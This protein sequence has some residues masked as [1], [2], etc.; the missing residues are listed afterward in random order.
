MTIYGAESGIAIVAARVCDFRSLANI[1]VELNNLTVLIGANNAGKTSFLDALFAAIGAGR[2]SLGADDVRLAPGELTA[3]KSRE[4]TIDLMLRPVDADGKVSST[5]PEGSFWTNLWGTTGIA[6]DDDISEFTGIRTTLRW[7]DVRGE[8]VLERRFLKEWKA[9]EDWKTAATQERPVTGAQ[10]EPLA[11]HYIDAKRDLDEDLRKPGSFWRRLTEDLGLSVDEI[12]EM[13][14]T[15]SGINERIVNKSAILKHLRESLSGL[16]SVVASDGG[17][18]EVAAVAR[19]LRDLSKGVDVAFNTPGAQSFPLARHGM[20]TRSLAALMVF[21]AY[22]SW[23]N[24]QATEGGDSIH[25]VLALEEPEAHLHPQAQRSLFSHIKHVAGQRIVSTHSPY[26]TGQAALEDLRLFFKSKGD[27]VVNKLD[28][29]TLGPNDVRKLQNTVIDTRGDILFSRGVVLFEGQTEEQALPVYASKYWGATIHEL[30]FCFVRVNGTDYFPFIW[31]AKALTIPWYVFADGEPRPVGDLNRAL[32][33]AG[34][35][36]SGECTN[37]VVLPSGNGF[38]AQLIDEGYLSE[39]ERVIDEVEKQE[40]Y[41]GDYIERLDRTKKKKG[42]I[43]DYKS[44]GGRAR[45]A[46]DYTEENKTRIARPLAE[47]ICSLPDS[48]RRFPANIKNLLEIIS[49]CHELSKS[50]DE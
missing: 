28:T 39:I 19:K 35:K 27:T 11:L 4:V 23:R 50:E 13:E 46:L 2:K 21:R 10:L 31:L 5:Y 26:F 44:E 47:V 12:E 33:R 40:N 22:A 41:L 29:S 7:S 6:I 14:K 9:F 25:S 48:D 16:Q 49:E 32:V 37:V 34:E 30:G 24:K 15:L 38:E 20:G 43:R 42:K 17:G 8:Y 36:E 45:A 18:V 3:P 1:E